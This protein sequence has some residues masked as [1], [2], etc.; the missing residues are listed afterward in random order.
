MTSWGQRAESGSLWLHGWDEGLCQYEPIESHETAWERQNISL[1]CLQG[2]GL[3]RKEKGVLELSRHV[4]SGRGWFSPYEWAFLSPKENQQISRL[5]VISDPN[6]TFPGCLGRPASQPERTSLSTFSV[7]ATWFAFLL[8]F[9][10]IIW[11]FQ[12]PL[13]FVCV[14]V[15]WLKK[16]T[17]F[18]YVAWNS[19]AL[20]CIPCFIAGKDTTAAIYHQHTNMSLCWS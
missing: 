18:L 2:G 8:H 14:C 12:M 17:H 16:I 6:P 11:M 1:W 9:Y 19:S 13:S 7:L 15:F 20:L 3:M 4:F 10:R 5:L